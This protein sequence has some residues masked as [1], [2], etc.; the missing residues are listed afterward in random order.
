MNIIQQEEL[1]KAAGMTRDELAQSLIDKEALTKIGFKDATAAKAKYEELRKTMSAQEAAKALGDEAL[2]NQ[3]EQQSVKERFAQAT[4]KLKKVFIQ[5]AEPILAIVSSLADLVSIILP[6]INHLLKSIITGFQAM[7]DT[8][9]SILNDNLMGI[10]DIFDGIIEIF[11]GDFT[12]GLKQMG[13]GLL[14]IILNPF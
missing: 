4:E 14:R 11:T 13:T 8:L 1:A 2:A 6:L 10:K 9:S 12:K 5:I 7:G 3:H